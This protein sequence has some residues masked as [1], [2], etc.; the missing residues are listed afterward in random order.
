MIELILIIIGLIVFEV[1]SSI[2]NAVVNADVLATM[3]S[4]KARK[5]FLFWGILFAV[6]VVRGLLPSLIVFFANPN[7]GVF[8]AFQAMWS[9]DPSVAAAI[10]ASTPLI[11]IAGGMF[12]ILLSLHWLFVEDKE[13]G[14]PLE[15]PIL[16]FGAVWFY[17]VAALLLI[18]VMMAL[19]NGAGE[20]AMPLA[21]AA[22]IGF[23][24]F[25]VTEGFKENAAKME[26]RLIADGETSAM[27]DWAKV[28][29]LEVLDLTFSIDGVVGAFAFT[30]I[31]PLILIGNGIGAIV[32]RQLTVHNIDRIRSY[33]YLKNGAMYSI[34]FLGSIMMLE[35]FGVH[36]PSWLSPVAAILIIGY[37]FNKSVMA[38][39]TR[40]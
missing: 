24:A 12:L 7:I 23:G 22:A 25:F 37:F 18:G 28:A 36:V 30:T 26:E 35:A 4:E 14:L 29:F 9:S 2:D 31:V 32:L 8:G 16:R 33:K 19:N 40:A 13:F 38:N 34:G 27:S 5:F 20:Q 3:K 1:V 21:L 10:H 15:R 17:S 11:L 39:R 6:F